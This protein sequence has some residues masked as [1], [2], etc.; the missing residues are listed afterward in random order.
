MNVDQNGLYSFGNN[1]TKKTY[2]YIYINSFDPFNP[3]ENLLS[4]SNVSCGSYYFVLG[5]RLETNVTYILVMTTLD[6]YIQGTFQ[7]FVTGPGNVNF[8]RT[9]KSTFLS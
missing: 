3:D 4:S 7:L 8:N 5:S 1:D 2:G 6:P 9:C